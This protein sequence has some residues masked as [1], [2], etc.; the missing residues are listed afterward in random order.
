MSSNLY[1]KY[2]LANRLEGDLDMIFILFFVPL[3]SKLISNTSVRACPT[4]NRCAQRGSLPKW[5]DETV[6][7]WVSRVNNWTL[8]LRKDIY[9]DE[10]EKIN[11]W[12]SRTSILTPWCDVKWWPHNLKLEK[13]CLKEILQEWN[14]L[15]EISFELYDMWSRITWRKEHWDGKEED[16]KRAVEV[17]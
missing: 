6:G 14:K 4:A 15:T 13:G 17:K 2:P 1:F 9:I 16:S 7:Q 8:L 10:Q 3:T 12:L 11:P 5:L